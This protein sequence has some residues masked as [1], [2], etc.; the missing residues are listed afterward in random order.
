VGEAGDKRTQRQPARGSL[1]QPSAK[2]STSQVR[3]R[4]H[5]PSGRGS[6]PH[7]EQQPSLERSLQ[8]FAERYGVPDREMQLV[9]FTVAGVPRSRC[10]A[11]MD[12]SENTCKTLARRLL[13]RCGARNLADLARMVLLDELE[14]DGRG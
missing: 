10:P 11:L 14:G 8:R 4:V 5:V 13:Q 2:S 6:A 1:E 9:R 7:V 3:A 12:V